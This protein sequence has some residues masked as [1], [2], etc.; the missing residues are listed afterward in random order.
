MLA[1]WFRMKYPHLVDGALAASAPLN[2]FNGTVAPELF[3]E[4]I[5]ND[6]KEIS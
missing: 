5:S 2:H 1:A 4:I 3:N 6:F